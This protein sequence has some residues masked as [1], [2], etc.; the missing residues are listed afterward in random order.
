MRYFLFITTLL[1]LASCSGQKSRPKPSTSIDWK[2][3]LF[4]VG[5]YGESLDSLNHVWY[6]FT[7]DSNAIG[8]IKGH[9]DFRFTLPYSIDGDT[10]IVDNHRF[11]Y[12]YFDTLSDWRLRKKIFNDTSSFLISRQDSITFKI[13]KLDGHDLVPEQLFIQLSS[14]SVDPKFFHADIRT[15]TASFPSD[16]HLSS[17]YD[18]SFL[19]VYCNL[20]DSLPNTS[21]VLLNDRD[22][23]YIFSY[24]NT[25]I[26]KRDDGKATD[27]VCTLGYGYDIQLAYD[28]LM[29]EYD[30]YSEFKV[31]PD[32]LHRYFENSVDTS[33]LQPYNNPHESFYLYIRERLHDYRKFPKGNDIVQKATLQEVPTGPPTEPII[34]ED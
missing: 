26:K 7:I 4:G 23:E 15:F 14:Q 21:K 28:S 19:L 33:R 13:D 18:S 16:F 25:L 22:R 1:L 9:P 32:Y 8:Q 11:L 30:N 2:E 17:Y 10:M 5:L 34:V 20:C 12:R 6:S 3:E 29:Y 27:I 24:I 31:V